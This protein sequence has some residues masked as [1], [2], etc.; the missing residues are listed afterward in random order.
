MDICCLD[1]EGVLVPEIWIQV[2]KKMRIHEL[3]LTTRDEP[4]YDKLMRRRLRIL[5]ERQIRLKDIQKIISTIKPLRGAVNFLKKLRLS[6]KYQI[7]ILS[8]TYDEFGWPLMRKLGMQVLFCNSLD[9][10]SKNGYIRRYDL[11]IKDG[12]TKSVRALKSIRFKVHAVGDSYNDLGMLRAAHR[13]ILFNPPT[14]IRLKNLQRKHPFK[15]ANTYSQLLKI[16]L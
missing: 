4:N 12:K 16:L 7:F 15:V 13:G 11:R 8:D 10:D 1:L 6:E 5:K 14:K 3:R 9:V 2:A